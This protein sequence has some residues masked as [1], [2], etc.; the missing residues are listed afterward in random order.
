MKKM[1]FLL[2]VFSL[3]IN[4]TMEEAENEQYSVSGLLTNGIF[5][6]TDATVDIDNL[7]Q[8]RVKSDADGFFKIDNIP[9]GT[10]E[11]NYGITI[12]NGSFSTM[13]ET[14]NITSDLSLN[15]LMLPDPVILDNPTIQR[16]LQSNE[17]NLSW[18]KYTG[19]DFREYKVYQHSSS[20]LDETTG[21]LLHVATSLNDTLFT[22]TLPHSSETY[23]RVFVRDDFGLLGGSNIVEVPIGMYESDPEITV[24]VETSY[25]LS[26]EEEQ[27]LYFDTPGPGL[28]SIA[29]FDQ[30]FDE[31]DAGSI[32][33]SAYNSDKSKTYFQNERLIQ[34]NGSPLPVY[35]PN[36]ERVYLKIDHY[37]DR[38]PGT[39]GVKVTPLNESDFSALEI[40][41]HTLKT[42]GL[43]DTELFTFEAGAGT[44]YEI[45]LVNTIDTGAYGDGAATY[46]S[47]YEEGADQFSTYK[48]SISFP[49]GTPKTIELSYESATKVFLIIDSAYWYVENSVNFVINEI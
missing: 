19:E 35:V 5:P 3:T 18:N 27:E 7:V 24:G 40:G 39:Y 1:L 33:V 44:A 36:A 2:F 15:A 29:W 16:D 22:T 8:Y 49:M 28:Y 6:V 11:L 25:Y 46:I 47:I 12:E 32:V 30:W 38:F 45:T 17:V 34:M 42:I 21:E 37:D 13:S 31:Y 41:V 48:E 26:A 14:I 4:C 10:H 20:G 43:G 9:E 23:F